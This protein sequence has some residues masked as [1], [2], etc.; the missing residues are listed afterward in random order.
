[1]CALSRGLSDRLACST[2]GNGGAKTPG[3]GS[4][5]TDSGD[6][7]QAQQQPK[8]VAPGKATRSS[9]LRPAPSQGDAVQRQERGTCAAAP[10][11]RSLWDHTMDP[12]MDAALRGT[13]PP[14]PAGETAVQAKGNA[15][16]SEPE[17]V[18]RAAARGV[19]GCGGALPYLEQIQASFGTA[20]DLSGVRAHI[21]GASVE[22]S[23]AIGAEA[24]ATGEDI[25]FR[26][27]PDLHT[28]AHEAAHVVQ[29]RAGVQL[30]GGVGQAGDAYEQQADAVAERVV[31][32]QSA[33]ELLGPA[34]G[35]GA[36][37]A[38]E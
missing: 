5:D 27:Q 10:Q 25:A 9:K 18:H 8:Q 4:K 26:G 34:P 31:A 28:V 17:Q 32:G 19:A 15:E 3:R 2:M 29:Q 16:T 20:H 24:Y 11:V 30:A 1:C 6:Q 36:D 33:A 7:S 12:W 13:R 35:A 22:A 23:E 38:R 14:D 37:P 21:G